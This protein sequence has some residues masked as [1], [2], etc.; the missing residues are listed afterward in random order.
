MLHTVFFD[1]CVQS[2]LCIPSFTITST[3]DI[4]NHSITKVITKSAN[5]ITTAHIPFSSSNVFIFTD[6]GLKGL[7]PLLPFCNSRTHITSVITFSD[8]QLYELQ[9]NAYLS[10]LC[11]KYHSL[12]LQLVLTHNQKHSTHHNVHISH[13]YLTLKLD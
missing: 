5:I 2:S 3:K 4:H 6:Q 7:L 13:M 8:P 11:T 10:L 12:F 9:G 1:S